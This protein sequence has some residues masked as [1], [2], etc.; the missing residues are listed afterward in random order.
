MRARS[1]GIRSGRK[2]KRRGAIPPAET[3]S[4]MTKR[5]WADSNRG[6]RNSGHHRQPELRVLVWQSRD[7]EPRARRRR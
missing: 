4:A 3:R 1:P 6:R 7:P 5:P 2:K